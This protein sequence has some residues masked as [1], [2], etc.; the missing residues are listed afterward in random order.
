MV[1]A[2]RRHWRVAVAVALGTM[3]GV[4][5]TLTFTPRSYT[6]TSVVALV[7][8]AEGGLNGEI[9]RLTIPTYTSVATSPSVVSAVADDLGEDADSIRAAISADIPP[10]SNTLRLSVT[11]DDPEKASELAD[12][13]AEALVEATSDDE[14]LRG[15][16]ASLSVPP[17]EPSWPPQES[18]YVLGGVLAV[19]LGALAA[20][21]AERRR[22]RIS[23]PDD[24][25]A[26]VEEAGLAIP[27]VAVGTSPA[28]ASS[29]VARLVGAQVDGGRP[30]TARLEIAAV[31][32]PS[33]RVVGLAISTAAALSRR[34]LG[35]HVSMQERDKGLVRQAGVDDELAF[36]GAGRLTWGFTDE[37]LS[38]ADGGRGSLGA[39]TLP[40]AP[41]VVVRVTDGAEHGG[42]WATAKSLVGVVP[43]VEAAADRQEVLTALNTLRELDAP[44]LGVCFLLRRPPFRPGPSA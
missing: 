39:D 2:L 43:V 31:G 26:V 28:G 18:G 20:W 37:P 16:L 38:S 21:V 32:R 5:L 17:S 14:L 30:D 11:W 29:V 27:V 6:A 22:P 7:P 41:D 10:A 44:L 19:I 13:V 35:V 40:A 1:T 36:T 15:S 23:S 12:G 33:P 34:G 42:E 8:R 4:V 25:V 9:L 3:L 24:V